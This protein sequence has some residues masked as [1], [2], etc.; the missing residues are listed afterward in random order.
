MFFGQSLFEVI[1]LRSV[2]MHRN[3]ES[4]KYIMTCSNKRDHLGFFINIDFLV[5]ADSPFLCGIQW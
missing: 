5:W 3:F 2:P 4:E 1:T